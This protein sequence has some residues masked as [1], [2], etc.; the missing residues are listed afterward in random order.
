MSFSFLHSFSI[1]SPFVFPFILYKPCSFNDN[2]IFNAC[3]RIDVLNALLPVKYNIANP[4]SLGGAYKKSIRL[5]TLSPPGNLPIAIDLVL[6]LLNNSVTIFFS[7]NALINTEYT[8]LSL[9]LSEII[10]SISPDDLTPL[11]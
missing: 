2:D 1:I 5:N 7:N 8:V 11:L 10:I 4:N 3:V 6:P 9:V